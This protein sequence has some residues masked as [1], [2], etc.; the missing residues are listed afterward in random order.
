MVKPVK[1][2]ASNRLASAEARRKLSRHP[3]AAGLDNHRIQRRRPP[4]RGLFLIIFAAFLLAGSSSSYAQPRLLIND[5]FLLLPDSECGGYTKEQ[6]QLMLNE[7]IYMP[8]EAGRSIKPDPQKPWVDIYADNSLILHRPG[9]GE[10]TYK[11]FDGERFQLL[12]ACRNRQRVSP[13]DT[14]CL[15][16]LCLL[17]HDANGIYRV[18]LRDYLPK[19]SI[20]DFVSADTVTDPR[21]L[22]DIAARAPHYGQCLTCKASVHERLALDIVTSTT[23][24][25]AACADFL[26][27]FGLLPLTWNGSAFAK[28]YDR[29]DHRPEQNQS[30]GGFK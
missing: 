14:A 22:Q 8:Q 12:A 28:P 29:A 4:A 2:E 24:N 15:M 17:R 7:A 13:M 26:P 10:I 18:E 1:I 11:S 16:N 9:Y 20:L 19:I 6:R 5:L 21:A 30:S 25:A 23:I 27:Q 3:A